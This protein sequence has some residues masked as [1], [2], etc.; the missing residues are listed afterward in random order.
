MTKKISGN[1]VRQQFIDFFKN[2]KGHT[3]V[4]SSSL[5]PGGDATLLFT[6]SGMV[7]FKDVFLGTDK[8]D[9][10]RAVD[11]QKCMR[12]AGKHNDLEDVGFDDTH[13]TFFEMLGN[14]S[15]GDYYKKEAI[16]WAWELLTEVWGL[17]KKSLYVTV[18]KDELNEIPTDDEALSQWKEQ[19]GLET[20]HILYY[21][22]KDNFWEMAETG[23]CG[24]NSEIHI[25]RGPEYGELTYR[26]D[27]TVDLDGPRFLELWNLVFIQYNRIDAK[28]LEPLPATHVDTGLGLE[29]IVSVLQDK[30]SNYRTDL[31]WPVIKRLQQITGHSDEEVETNFTPYRVIADHVRAASF[32]IADRVVPGNMGRNYVT[33]MVIRRAARFGS[34]LGLNEPF[35][36]KITNEIIE[37]YGDAYPE[38]V[39]NAQSIFD[40]FTREEEQFQ[41]TVESG[42]A[43]LEDIFNALKDKNEK[44]IKG[45]D[46]FR[47][48]ATYGLPFE[49]TRD[50]AQ[51]RGYDSDIEGFQAEA[52]KHRLA[53]GGGKAMGDQGGEDVEFFS[54]LFK[55]LLAKKKLKKAG[56][57]YN[58]YSPLPIKGEILA[59]I[60]NGEEIETA[61]P[62]DEVQIVLDT[63]NF[64]IEAGGQ[65]SD[66]GE[67]SGTGWTVK[68]KDVRRPVS[69]LIIHLGEVVE[70]N[71]Y[72]GAQSSAK[73]DLIRRQNIMR[74]HTATHLLH[75]EL[76]QVIG[77]HANQ[78]GSLVAPDRLRFDFTHPKAISKEDLNNI[79][80]GVNNHILNN[81]KLAIEVK[82]LVDAKAEGATALFGEKYGENVRTI[83]IGGETPFSYELC[84]GT[85]VDNTGEIGTFLIV[86]EGSVAA[87]IRRI[88]AITGR[89]AYEKIQEQF[90]MIDQLAE[91]VKSVPSQVKER[92]KSFLV[93]L[94]ETQKELAD[95]RQFATSRRF[96]KALENTKEIN[97][98]QLLTAVLPG[99]DRDTLRN[100]ADNFREKY[101][102]G[103]AVLATI[104]N[105]KP[106]LVATLTDDLV[107]KGLKAGDLINVV[108][109]PL[110]GKGGVRPHMAQA[111]GE[112]AEM[113]EE[114]LENAE[115]WVN[116]I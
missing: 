66:S 79:E 70:G 23:P 8:R 32:L 40:S 36:A 69:E 98:I 97:G 37:L 43:H 7:Q 87:G 89:A 64:Y 6:N 104:V 110:G 24:P 91:M 2:K 58:P 65:V 72:V 59:I 68:I 95:I 31:F 27:G 85:H 92:I 29:R 22:R 1:E 48:H 102:S 81:H 111:G 113:I 67:I 76:R 115:A 77:N 46:S 14:W 30:E 9:Y 61:N 5:V 116:E 62:G 35:L 42:L 82:S 45:E 84:G 101:S 16:E 12:V 51:E 19:L 74:N 86:S 103:A 106:A 93:E 18:F 53:S 3:V 39:E 88:E 80:A 21:G 4:A 112:D 60:K 34:K 44:V 55:T 50:I 41:R 99:A 108:A 33:R 63:T 90:Q 47:L 78:A 54:S 11:S 26:E 100:L 38:L 94:S 96:E 83:Q 105:G 107:K 75:T 17:S 28:T 109:I 56:V 52:E 114:A 13:H 25:D 20:D 49:I 71:P 10:V 57:A 15:F 73:V